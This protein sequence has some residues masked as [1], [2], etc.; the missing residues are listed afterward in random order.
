MSAENAGCLVG[1]L[2]VMTDD[3][4]NRSVEGQPEDNLN[5]RYAEEAL[6]LQ[7][8]GEATGVADP[9]KVNNKINTLVKDLGL[10]ERCEREAKT[11]M[12]NELTATD[13]FAVAAGLWGVAA[14][15]VSTTTARNNI[16]R[17]MRSKGCE[18]VMVKVRNV[19]NTQKNI[20]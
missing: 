1:G 8:E 2:Q 15:G 12:T 11:S 6:E 7:A 4:G 20:V 10:D 9:T 18:P 5:E 3:A 16:D 19:M 13:S 17:H 14:G